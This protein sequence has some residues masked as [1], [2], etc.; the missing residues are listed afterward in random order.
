MWR[1]VFELPAQTGWMAD[2]GGGQKPHQQQQQQQAAA[3]SSNI[4]SQLDTVY[5]QIRPLYEQVH[6]YVRPRLAAIYRDR[7]A[8]AAS[9]SSTVGGSGGDPAASAAASFVRS[10]NDF[11]VV[12]EALQPTIINKFILIIYFRPSIS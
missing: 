9:I 8:S 7:R 10:L 1:S 5:D 12:T 11:F 2:G 3:A 6:A 4:Q